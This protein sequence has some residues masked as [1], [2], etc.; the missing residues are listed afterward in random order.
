MAQNKPRETC[1]AP[2]SLETFR[3]EVYAAEV[4]VCMFAAMHFFIRFAH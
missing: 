4:F 1:T 2:R 3:H